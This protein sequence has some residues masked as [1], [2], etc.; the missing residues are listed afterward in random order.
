MIDT[1]VYGASE[2]RDYQLY[3]DG[4]ALDGAGYPLV[5]SNC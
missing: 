4:V 1:I 2:P 3:D 5:A